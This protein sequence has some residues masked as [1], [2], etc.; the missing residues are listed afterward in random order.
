MLIHYEICIHQNS[1]MYADA[2]CKIPHPFHQRVPSSSSFFIQAI[3]LG[4]TLLHYRPL[5]ALSSAKKAKWPP[6]TGLAVKMNP[7]NPPE[8]S[9]SYKSVSGRSVDVSLTQSDTRSRMSLR[10]AGSATAA[11]WNS[12]SDLVY[13]WRESRGRP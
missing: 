6:T 10:T 3:Y 9:V 4:P 8:P 5:Q 11:A 2:I 12:Q 1:P 13:R 7:G